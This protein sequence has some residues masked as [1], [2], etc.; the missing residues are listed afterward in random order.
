M[1]VSG[2]VGCG[3]RKRRRARRRAR[4]DGPEQKRMIIFPRGAGMAVQARRAAGKR[5]TMRV[6]PTT[7]GAEP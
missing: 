1:T 5:V 7:G 2:G 6:R 3:H 4:K